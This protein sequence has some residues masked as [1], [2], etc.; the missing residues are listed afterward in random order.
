MVSKE[1]AV[2]K[3]DSTPTKAS[4]E[5]TLSISTV[6]S[7]KSPSSIKVNYRAENAEDGCEDPMDIDAVHNT[8]QKAIQSATNGAEEE[9]AALTTENKLPNIT[10]AANFSSQLKIMT[11]VDVSSCASTPSA[12][13]TP[14]PMNLSGCADKLLH[15]SSQEAHN[16]SGSSSV[17]HSNP[18]VVANSNLNSSNPNSSSHHAR[19]SF[20]TNQAIPLEQVEKGL[21]DPRMRH[22]SDSFSP[23][24][25][26]SYLVNILARLR[27]NSKSEITLIMPKFSSSSSDTD[28][29]KSSKSSTA[30]RTKETVNKV[31]TSSSLEAL[32]SQRIHSISE[33][34]KGGATNLP[35]KNL[36][37]QGPKSEDE[38][39]NLFVEDSDSSSN[40]SY[41]NQQH[42]RASH[43]K[44]APR[45]SISSMKEE[46][47]AGA[48]SSDSEN[49][50]PLE[51]RIKMLD[52]MINQSKNKKD[53]TTAP[54][55][56][57][58]LASASMATATC[59][60]LA[61]SKQPTKL[62]KI[63]DLDEQRLHSASLISNVSFANLF[64]LKTPVGLRA[65]L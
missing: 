7:K 29:K 44:S 56:A 36:G 45:L 46:T 32:K 27:G 33:S 61:A 35:S 47:T 18:G 19:S 15:N 48:A 14:N 55:A 54:V 38:N 37:K 52:E 62:S 11:S 10:K 3:Q 28:N 26:S 41:A 50:M 31:T 21:K 20:V 12:P 65:Y 9:P 53:T 59:S 34:G 30:S 5:A 6:D 60:S 40:C 16:T 24:D 64:L 22:Q 13:T 63:F 49:T 25:N 58:K 1:Q 8:Q 4:T 39:D 42:Q 23:P 17:P 43:L 51:E 2:A 57:Q